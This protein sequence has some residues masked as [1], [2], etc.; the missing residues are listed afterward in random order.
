M[1]EVLSNEEVVQCL[2]PFIATK[3]AEKAAQALISKSYRKWTEKDENCRDDITC[4]IVFLDVKL[5]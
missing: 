2:S 4:V 1:W 3:Q 5:D